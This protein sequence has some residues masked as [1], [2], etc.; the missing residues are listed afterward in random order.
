MLGMKSFRIQLRGHT[1]CITNRR[2]ANESSCSF[3]FFFNFRK[4]FEEN[5]QS[6]LPKQTVPEGWVTKANRLY[7][8]ITACR[9][10]I[11]AYVV[12]FMSYFVFMEVILKKYYSLLL[13]V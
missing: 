2:W 1:K 5:S 10:I 9:N 8:S 3:P 6:C 11:Y 4:E 13:L 12:E 7:T